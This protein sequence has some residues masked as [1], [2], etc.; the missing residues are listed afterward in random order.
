MINL[1]FIRKSIIQSKAKVL[2]TKSLNSTYN[3]CKSI[4]YSPD[5]RF[6]STSQDENKDNKPKNVSFIEKY[7][8]EEASVASPSFKNRW[9]MVLPAFLTHMC[10][11]SPF[12]VILTIYLFIY[13]CRVLY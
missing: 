13:L 10:I 12:A 7:F 3:S 5:I 9:A 1:N 4:K 8:G 6:F 11:G 2:S